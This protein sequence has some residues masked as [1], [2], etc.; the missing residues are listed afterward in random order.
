MT[1]STL[2]PQCHTYKTLRCGAIAFVNFGKK[3]RSVNQSAKL[4]CVFG[5]M[6]FFAHAIISVQSKL[7]AKKFSILI[8]YT[9]G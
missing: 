9:V 5:T 4:C 1:K 8:N 7:Y 3:L 2:T 6:L